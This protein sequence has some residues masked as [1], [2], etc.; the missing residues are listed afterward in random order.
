DGV[1]FL[2]DLRG[3]NLRLAGDPAI[4]AEDAAA[5][6]QVGLELEGQLLTVF[7]VGLV[8]LRR[9]TWF[10]PAALL[11][12]LIE[13]EAVHTIQ[14]WADLKNRLDWDRRCYAFFHPSMPDQP[15]VFVYVG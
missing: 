11:E 8:H 2:V 4:G 13:Y 12:K 5:L 1:K 6:E 10:A 7:D 14:S 15:L 9:L 3:D